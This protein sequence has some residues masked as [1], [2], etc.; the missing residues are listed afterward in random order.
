LDLD[1]AAGEKNKKD[2]EAE[3]TSLEKVFDN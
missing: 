2:F 1:I 3:K